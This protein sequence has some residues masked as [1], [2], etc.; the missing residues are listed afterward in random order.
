MKGGF[1]LVLIG[2]LVLYLGITGKFGCFAGAFSCL[3]L[4]T[5]SGA[6]QTGGSTTSG[7]VT[8]GTSLTSFPQV[9]IPNFQLPGLPGIQTPPFV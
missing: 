2:L 7:G 6:T 3:F 5:G 4:D 1:I 9:N 8:L